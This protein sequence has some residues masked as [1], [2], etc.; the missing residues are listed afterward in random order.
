[1]YVFTRDTVVHIEV[2]ATT[3]MTSEVGPNELGALPEASNARYATFSAACVRAFPPMLSVSNTVCNV[4]VEVK[5]ESSQLT[6]HDPAFALIEV[7]LT[8]AALG[9]VRGDD[10]V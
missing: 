6:A 3:R 9:D 1:M 8:I 10:S 2:L 7:W 5:G 4:D